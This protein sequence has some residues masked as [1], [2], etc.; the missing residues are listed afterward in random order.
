MHFAPVFLFQI[1]LNFSSK[2]FLSNRLTSPT[3]L[4]TVYL[5]GYF[6]T[7][8]FI[9]RHVPKIEFTFVRILW[10]FLLF[11]ATLFL[12]LTISL[13]CF[14]TIVLF[15]I[16][17]SHTLSSFSLWTSYSCFVLL[18]GQLLNFAS[19]TLF[20][21]FVC[22]FLLLVCWHNIN[23]KLYRGVDRF[24]LK[25]LQTL[26]WFNFYGSDFGFNSLLIF[27]SLQ[28]ILFHF[29][30]NLFCTFI[31]F[32]SFLLQIFMRMSMLVLTLLRL[33]LFYVTKTIYI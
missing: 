10:F 18:L 2:W 33:S 32:S 1:L 8:V 28:L 26:P 30:C 31:Y 3:S 7:V 23:H 21:L 20:L 15:F 25:F 9:Y 27:F 12:S 5:Q 6:F 4:I 19:I 11:Y 29:L 14:S 22:F 17:F 24:F 16:L 13:A